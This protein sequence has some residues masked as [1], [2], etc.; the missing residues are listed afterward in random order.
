MI[1]IIASLTDGF[2][3]NGGKMERNLK[4]FGSVY[5]EKETGKKFKVKR[6]DCHFVLI[7][8]ENGQVEKSNRTI[9]KEKF[10]FLKKESKQMK[11]GEFRRV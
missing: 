3:I 9:L 5:Q 6:I 11:F 7:M 4:E 1:G 2:T 10:R 8:D